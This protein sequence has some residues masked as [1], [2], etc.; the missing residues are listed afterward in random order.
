MNRFY[1]SNIAAL[2]KLPFNECLAKSY[3][4]KAGINAPQLSQQPSHG[5]C[6]VK[7][8]ISNK[9][10]ALLTLKGR[11]EEYAYSSEKGKKS[12]I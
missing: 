6:R 12:S 10:Q 2:P 9:Y 3:D 1:V 7:L 4:R 8:N 11:S 5:D